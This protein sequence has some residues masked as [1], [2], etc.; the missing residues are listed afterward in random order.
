MN[1]RIEIQI[2]TGSDHTFCIQNTEKSKYIG[3][4]YFHRA[5]DRL[6]YLLQLNT[7]VYEN[8][9]I[10][11]KCVNSLKMFNKGTRAQVVPGPL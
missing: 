8:E 1:F 6:C 11:R 5:D 7:P 10:F 3:N 4:L 9:L 2:I